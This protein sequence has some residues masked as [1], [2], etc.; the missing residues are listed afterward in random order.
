MP[1]PVSRRA[2]L[3]G[4]AALATL[5]GCA[6]EKTAD[7][8]PEPDVAILLTALADERN[9]ISLYEAVIAAHK[10]LPSHFADALQHH[11]DH[12]AALEKHYLPGTGDATATPQITSPTAA[13]PPSGLAAAKAALRAAERSAAAARVS[14]VTKV[15][16]GM[17]QLLASIGTC[18]AGHA[19][20]L[21]FGG[22]DG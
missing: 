16:P 1:V 2:L 11:R 22:S 18:E 14:D 20:V 4:G 19:T 13:A 7:L 10:G 21:A 12:L 9:L 15:A 5:A 6:S 8:R 3:G 17:A